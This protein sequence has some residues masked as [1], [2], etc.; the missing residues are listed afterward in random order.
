MAQ[1]PTPDETNN[2]NQWPERVEFLR[3]LAQVVRDENL[4]ELTLEQDGL[5]ISLKSGRPSAIAPPV[6]YA[7]PGMPMMAA[8]PEAA[9]EEDVPAEALPESAPEHRVPVVSPMV[10]VFYR[11]KS[12]DE[13]SFVE[14]GDRVEVGQ[15]VGLVEAMKT[16]N[17]IMSEVEGEVVEIAAENGQLIET[18]GPLVWIKP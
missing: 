17:E 18:G 6:S 10:G 15:I 14:V 8:A 16:F 9:W 13:P 4:S 1:N 5:Q 3:G 11:A 12:P 2:D 7:M